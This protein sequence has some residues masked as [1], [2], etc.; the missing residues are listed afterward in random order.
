MVGGGGGGG[1]G[2]VIATRACEGFVS[3]FGEEVGASGEESVCFFKKSLEKE[4]LLVEKE[5]LYMVS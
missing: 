2:G 4:K 5:D 3:C 1:R